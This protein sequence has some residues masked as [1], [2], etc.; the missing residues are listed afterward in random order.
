M[1]SR[2]RSQWHTALISRVM[3]FTLQR[4]LNFHS[5]WYPVYTFLR[6]TFSAPRGLSFWSPVST[7]RDIQSSFHYPLHPLPLRIT[8]SVQSIWQPEFTSY[9][10][11]INIQ[12]PFPMTSSLHLPLHAV[13]TTFDISVSLHK[14]FHFT[15][16]PF[17]T[18][19]ENRFLFHVTSSF[20]SLL[21]PVLTPRVIEM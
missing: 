9:Y 2:L 7:F 18:T 14:I 1:T 8:P 21:H 10:T 11:L 20:H 15:W 12:L 4:I 5:S 13:S 16:Q 17:F 6:H 19:H 3:R